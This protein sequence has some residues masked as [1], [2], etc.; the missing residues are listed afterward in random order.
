MIG[1]IGTSVEENNA[2]IALSKHFA[3]LSLPVPIIYAVSNDGLVYLQTDLGSTSLY[4]AL[5][6]GRE[7]TSG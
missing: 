6:E 4:D 5:K 1:V 7:S 2:F 3:S